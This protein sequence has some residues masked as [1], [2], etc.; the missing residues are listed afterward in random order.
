MDAALSKLIKDWYWNRLLPGSPRQLKSYDVAN[1]EV[2]KDGKV[3]KTTS[4]NAKLLVEG[5]LILDEIA[6]TCQMNFKDAKRLKVV[7]LQISGKN[8]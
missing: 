4:D 8:T 6:K 7:N 2:A 1:C 5:K 3:D